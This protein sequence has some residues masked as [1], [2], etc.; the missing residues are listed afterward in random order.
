MLRCSCGNI[1][2]VPVLIKKDVYNFGLLALRLCQSRIIYKDIAK[3]IAKH[4]FY[5]WFP[6]SDTFYYRGGQLSL[7]SVFRTKD[8]LYELLK[9]HPQVLT[10]NPGPAR[11]AQIAY[12]YGKAG[13][14]VCYSAGFDVLGGL[15]M[16]LGHRNVPN[17]GSLYFKNGGCIVPIYKEEKDFNYDLLILIN[18]QFMKE[19]LDSLKNRVILLVNY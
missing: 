16:L 9:T 10:G 6:V 3:Y 19:V 1:P 2:L 15:K 18:N 11:L 7:S 4:F 5:K 17:D 12:A 14:K 8:D 13:K